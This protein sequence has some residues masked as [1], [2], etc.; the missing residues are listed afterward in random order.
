MNNSQ[1]GEEKKL[2]LQACATQKNWVF[3]KFKILKHVFDQSWL[4]I[5]STMYVCVCVW[6]FVMIN[7]LSDLD[8]AHYSLVDWI[9]ANMNS[10]ITNKDDDLVNNQ[11]TKRQKVD[12]DFIGYTEPIEI[13]LLNAHLLNLK[14]E[15]KQQVCIH[16]V[17]I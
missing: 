2:A 3:F 13:N 6:R 12:H 10:I 1:Q 14:E 17:L 9:E 11:K 8:K 15:F 7:F 5:S 4:S 16:L